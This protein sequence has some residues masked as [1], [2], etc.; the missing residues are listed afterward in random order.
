MAKP[1]ASQLMRVTACMMIAVLVFQVF[2]MSWRRDDSASSSWRTATDNGMSMPEC[3]SLQVHVPV[4]FAEE[5][6]PLPEQ[7]ARSGARMSAEGAEEDHP[8]ALADASLESTPFEVN[9]R[10]EEGPVQL[11]YPADVQPSGAAAKLWPTLVP[12]GLCGKGGAEVEVQSEFVPVPESG[13]STQSLPA[14][15][16][17]VRTRCA[18]SGGAA[19][20]GSGSPS[21]WSLLGMMN[22]PPAVPG[23][24]LPPT[25]SHPHIVL[26]GEDGVSRNAFLRHAPA[27]QAFMHNASNF[28]D[29]EL[30]EFRY[31][32]SVH[33]GTN[34]NL[35]SMFGNLTFLPT[36]TSRGMRS[37]GTDP[38]NDGVPDS[39][40]GASDKAA[41]T[42]HKDWLWQH[43]KRRGYNTWW[44]DVTQA[45]SVRGL[46]LLDGP[47]VTNS[48]RYDAS[49]DLVHPHWLDKGGVQPRC[50]CL[51]ETP[52]CRTST[53]L[54]NRHRLSLMWQRLM[55][56]WRR[57]AHR[58]PV[59]LSAW[60]AMSEVPSQA[61]HLRV[62]DAYNALGI[63]ELFST[64]QAR[65]AFV[66]LYSDHGSGGSAAEATGITENAER[67]R[68]L[69]YLWAPKWWLRMHPEAHEALIAN[70]DSLLSHF[71]LYATVLEIL[72]GPGSWKKRR[73]AWQASLFQPVP[74]DRTCASAHIP[75]RHCSCPQWSASS[76]TLPQMEALE[77]ALNQDL[78]A[79]CIQPL[80]IA[81]VKSCVSAT[82]SRNQAAAG[83]GVSAMRGRSTFGGRMEDVITKVTFWLRQKGN[84]EAP[85]LMRATIFETGSQREVTELRQLSDYHGQVTCLGAGAHNAS[86]AHRCVCPGVERARLG[87]PADDEQPA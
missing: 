76:L 11:Q 62:H 77:Q 28:P 45:K 50:N 5:E 82:L 13:I 19:G 69:L 68:P 46:A 10:V 85:P 83:G 4:A 78:P 16:A 12:T 87:Q 2:S 24:V 21:H 37:L 31:L 1:G 51:K 59:F 7:G 23:V 56:A 22:R 47:F 48:R 74:R 81:S 35:H 71:D 27:V 33:Y 57:H 41:Y 54:Y 36:L 66:L 55:D 9:M 63:R 34:G 39:F 30:F 8:C 29:H 42:Q 6:Q 58:S 84:R 72:D 49:M 70:Q 79:L 64:A 80:K 65:T 25:T 20:A 32:H 14:G 61:P 26:L 3:P 38:D 18:S 43:A 52:P 67:Q 53:C 15:T 73:P 40:V 17:L 60:N 75:A 44:F 86:M